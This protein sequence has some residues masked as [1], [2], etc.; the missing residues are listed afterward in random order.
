[1]VMPFNLPRT[2]EFLWHL[3]SI[4]PDMSTLAL[5]SRMLVVVVAEVEASAE[6][7]PRMM[8]VVTE[9]EEDRIESAT[10]VVSPDTRNGIALKGIPG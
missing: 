2:K 9:V 10:P 6:V 4:S 8:V 1:M 3:P 7:P 5:R